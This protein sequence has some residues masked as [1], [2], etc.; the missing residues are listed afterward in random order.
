MLS[1]S[2]ALSAC[3]GGGSGGG[4]FPVAAQASTPTQSTQSAGDSTPQGPAAT[5]E[6]QPQVPPTAGQPDVSPVTPVDTTPVA[7]VP[8]KVDALVAGTV[9][10]DGT[11][12][13]GP[14]GMTL[15]YAWSL[16]SKPSA[17]N[18]TLLDSTT[19]RAMLWPDVAGTYRLKLVVSGGGKVSAPAYATVEAV[20]T[21][22][23]PP[24]ASFKA[25]GFAVGDS[26]GVGGCSYFRA[27]AN[28]ATFW[29]F[30][31]NAHGFCSAPSN[32]AAFPDVES[33]GT[34]GGGNLSGVAMN[35][36]Y[37]QSSG[38]SGASQA[39]WA[40]VNTLSGYGFGLSAESVELAKIPAGKVTGSSFNHT[41]YPAYAYPH[42][43]GVLQYKIEGTVQPGNVPT[44]WEALPE[45]SVL[46]TVEG[47][48]F[49][50]GQPG[51]ASVKVFEKT[52]TTDYS[53][54]IPLDLTWANLPV[55]FAGSSASYRVSVTART[56][57]KRTSD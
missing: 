15:S 42:T 23:L 13:T 57:F 37:L 1:C 7:I 3:G 24:L 47:A 41:M 40:N 28:F 43:T 36:R 10:V 27:P 11:A 51:Y 8:S 31:P 53:E 30:N 32:P 14:K 29:S 46:L 16:E 19:Q 34:N 56:V 33:Q 48:T 22:L 21:G 49:E 39:T 18:S 25:S 4:S 20:P 9:Q 45:I 26:A 54:T 35:V 12:S 2:V 6:I 55:A 52:Y 5:P 17:S 44:G 50:N 38:L